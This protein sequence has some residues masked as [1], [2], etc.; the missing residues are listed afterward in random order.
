LVEG[1]VS[2]KQTEESMETITDYIKGWVKFMG[3]NSIGVTEL[4]PY[5]LYS[6]MGR[7]DRYNSKPENKHKYAVA[8]TMEM[9]YD[10][11]NQAPKSLAIFE[12]VR[13]Y[14]DVGNATVLIADFIRQLGYPA[15]AHIDGN[16]HVVCPLV[17]RDAGLGEIGRMGVLMTPELGPRIRIGVITTDM[18]LSLSV[19]KYDSTMIDFCNLCKKCAVV[20]PSQAISHEDREEIDGVIR[21]QINSEKC[22]TYMN[23]V[24]TDCAKCMASC[25]YS[26]RDIFYSHRGMNFLLRNSALFRRIAPFL[27]DAKYGKKPKTPEKISWDIIKKRNIK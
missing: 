5:H 4:K 17:A 10:L 14:F 18:P 1:K 13:R 8:I 22:F 19:R 12:A 26:H 11:T 7:G 9:N 20:C 25:P 21:W 2:D 15:R 16:Y 24:G 3:A 6:D 23:K 27:E